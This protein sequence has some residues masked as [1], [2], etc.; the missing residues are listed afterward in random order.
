MFSQAF[1]FTLAREGGYSNNP[2]DSGGA[3]NHGITQ[4]TYDHWLKEQNL[5][6]QNV[7]DIPWESVDAIYKEEYWDKNKCD[8]LTPK[9]GIALFDWSVTSGNYA[10]IYLQQLLGVMQDG[11]VGPQTIQAV[12]HH[13]EEELLE[14]Y[15]KV[16]EEYYEKLA[17]KRPKDQ[18]FLKG[19]LN[20]VQQLREY[21]QTI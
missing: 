3:T 6:S 5:P 1:K 4:H 19:W 11:Q 14:S 12:S 7:E 15:L 10:A 21:L 9:I 16:R 20:R 8:A 17:V 13:N 2:A 18:V